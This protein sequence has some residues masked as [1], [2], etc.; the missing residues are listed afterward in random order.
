MP[1]YMPRFRHSYE[2]FGQANPQHDTFNESMNTR[3]SLVFVAFGL[4]VSGCA[5]IRDQSVVFKGLSDCP[6]QSAATLLANEAQLGPASSTHA[7]QCALTVARESGDAA[8]NRSALP[9]RLALHLAERETDAQKKVALANE[10]VQLAERALQQGGMNNG[11]VQ[12]YLAANLGLSVRDR[13][14][15]GGQQ[16]PR[17]EQTLQKAMQL[18]PGIDQ[19]GPLRLLGMLYLKAP[20]WPTGIG[21]G[22][23]ALDLL[24][25]ASSRYPG[26]PLN[27]LFYA[28][29]LWEVDNQADQARAA[30]EKGQRALQDGAWGYNKAVWAREFAAFAKTLPNSP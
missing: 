15:E 23:K 8:L 26:H 18:E 29:A 3:F 13:P 9:S 7:L 25:Q 24:K 10:G 4:V 17:L 27:D 16:L 1:T 20:P 30:L 6:V 14:L 12:Y 19:G 2:S 11:A 22:D 28:Q 21:D 5:S